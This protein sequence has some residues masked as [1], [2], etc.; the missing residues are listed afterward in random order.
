MS[1]SEIAELCRRIYQKHRRALDLIFEHR[2][3]RQAEIR[4]FVE[5]LIG[6]TPRLILDRSS[7]TEIRFLPEE[8]DVPALRQGAGWR[9]TVRMLLFAVI[10]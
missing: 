7:K 9:S 4:D 8:W 5:Q 1:D 6:E 2:P 3:D 10:N